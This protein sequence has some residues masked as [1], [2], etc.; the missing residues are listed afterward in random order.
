[1]MAR[2]QTLWLTADA[3]TRKDW[4]RYVDAIGVAITR[5]IDVRRVWIA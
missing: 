2:P 3:T 1:M 4:P 5:G